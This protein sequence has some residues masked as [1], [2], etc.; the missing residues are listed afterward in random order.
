MDAVVVSVGTKSVPGVLA[1]LAGRGASGAT[2]M[3]DTPVLDPSNLRAARLFERFPAVLASEDNYSLP[4]YVLARSL[5]D[6][7]RIGR[8]QR[9]Y[10]FHSGY[11]H[12]ALAALRRLTGT[13]A[14]RV[15]VDRSNR[16]CAE[17][18]S[19]SPAAY[20]PSSSSRAATRS[21]GP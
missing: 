5:L 20:G 1:E 9:A 19:R 7:G 10:L 12:H 3:L 16:W 17:V 15:S 14:R 13:R 8:L 6:E 21:A 4:L 11:R 18:H 2:L